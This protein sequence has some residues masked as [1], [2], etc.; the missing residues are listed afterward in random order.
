VRLTFVIVVVSDMR[1]AVSF[2]GDV[3]GLTLR[4]ESPDWTEFESGGAQRA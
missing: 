3:V 2:Y 1:A 4:F